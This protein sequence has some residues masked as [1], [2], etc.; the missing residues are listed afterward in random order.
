MDRSYVTQPN[1]ARHISVAD[2]SSEDSSITRIANSTVPDMVL[3]DSRIGEGIGNE[4]VGVGGISANDISTT[5]F[6]NFDGDNTTDP[7]ALGTDTGSFIH[8]NSLL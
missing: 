6:L 8:T 7:D 2:E 1:A 5:D 3:L 4:N